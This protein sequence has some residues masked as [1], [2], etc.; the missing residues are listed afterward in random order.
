M[1]INRSIHMNFKGP[2][3]KFNRRKRIKPYPMGS[4]GIIRGE[5]VINTRNH[6]HNNYDFEN[7]TKSRGY[8]ANGE[9]G[10]V[11]RTFGDSTLNIE[12][13]SQ[14]LKTFGYYNKHFEE[15]TKD[16]SIELA[17]ALT[18]HKAQGS[19]F[20]KVILIIP[21]PCPL[22]SRELIYTALTRQKKGIILLHQ[23]NPIDLLKFSSPEHS[24]TLKR[25]TNLFSDPKPRKIKD[26]FLE[27]NLI[28]TTSRG[29]AVRSKSEVIIADRLAAANI[30]YIYEEELLID[31]L[32][33]YPDFTIHDDDSGIDYYWEH[34][35]MLSNPEYKEK[36][37]NKLEWYH[38]NG[39][40]EEGGKR[41]TLIITCDDEK[42]GISSQEIDRVIREKLE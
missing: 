34:L 15:G 38:K 33:R 28:H 40:K 36:W 19:E 4:E 25:Y 31:D 37:G 6:I 26:T 29:E 10:I 7:K 9:I 14:P 2:Q 8:V 22:V 24:E 5:K 42:G 35:G 32:P 16:Y 20:G 39:I 30:D 1:E 13:S 21:E 23:G 12:F 18:V 11:V 27:A 41:G 17:Y 3:I